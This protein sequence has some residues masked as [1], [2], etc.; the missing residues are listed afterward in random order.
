MPDELDAAIDRKVA[1]ARNALRLS[2]EH[3]LGEAQRDAPLDTGALRASG[4]I[5][6]R[7]QPDGGM[8]AE[9]QFN[10]PYAAVQHERV[11]YVHPRAGRAKYLETP[12]KA[13]AY[14]YREAISRAADH[15]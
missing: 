3:L 7:E 12:L 5:V 11:D 9:V 8:T 14:R 1:A 10:T 6:Y 15:A 2:A 4:D 13:N